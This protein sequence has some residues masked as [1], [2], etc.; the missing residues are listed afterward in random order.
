M[1]Q[2]S[3]LSGAGSFGGWAVGVDSWGGSYGG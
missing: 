1:V 2:P 3:A